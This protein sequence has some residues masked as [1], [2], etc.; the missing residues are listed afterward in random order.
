MSD[1]DRAQLMQIIQTAP[2]NTRQEVTIGGTRY[3]IIS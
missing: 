2:P 1:A 3:K